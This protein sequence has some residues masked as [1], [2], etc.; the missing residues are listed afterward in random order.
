MESISDEKL[1]EYIS[2][3]LK[4]DKVK[5]MDCFMQHGTTSTFKHSLN[6]ARLSYELN[7]KFNLN[8]NVKDLLTGAML[9]DFYLYDWHKR[10]IKYGLHG[11]NHSRI[12]MENA[13]KYFNVNENVQNIIL[14]HMWPLNITKIPKSKEAWIVCIAD[15]ICSIKDT[16]K[17]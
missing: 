14:T 1:L 16:I 9:H 7:K 10:S 11:F 3:I 12:A 17:R 5:S 4:H 2:D 6:V 13:I 15:K 8:A